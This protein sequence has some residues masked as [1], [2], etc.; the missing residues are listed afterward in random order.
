M[1][2]SGGVLSGLAGAVV[3]GQRGGQQLRDADEA[4][5]RAAEDRTQADADRQIQRAALLAGLADKG[6]VPMG[7]SGSGAGDASEP[8]A[9]PPVITP[10]GTTGYGRDPSRSK[11]A[12]QRATY[13][14]LGMRPEQADAAIAT[15]ALADEFVKSILPKQPSAKPWV[16]DGYDD[17]P[18]GKQTWLA[19]LRAKTDASREPTQR[20]IDP[21][22]PDGI[23]AGARR[24]GEVAKAEAPFKKDAN[25]GPMS[26]QRTL[27]LQ[28]HFNSDPIVKDASDIAQAFQKM[29]ASSRDPSAAGDM[30][31]LYGY[32]KLL[33]PGSVVRESEFANAARSGSLPQQI[34][35]FASKIISGQRLTPAQRTDFI[36]R[37]EQ[38]ARAQRAQ[39]AGTLKRYGDMATRYGVD[40][41]DIT[42]DPFEV[43]FD[44]A[45]QTAAGAAQPHQEFS[46][47]EVLA[48][49]K[50]GA[51]T[52][53]EIATWIRGH[54]KP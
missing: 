43:V 18:D 30:S 13:I 52:D 14:R 10:L 28:Q 53:A 2:I 40:P 49:H 23:A 5:R 20:N 47:A 24:A 31:L 1:G 42:Y 51:K 39:L 25:S 29:R 16:R 26:I 4:K 12:Q 34:Q 45:T 19:D 38:V 36:N 32:M 17:T 33:D 11:A 48:A 37:A 6:I 50:A 41:R 7:A 46:D 44:A 8:A 15:P 22:S 3:R 54:R 21:L 27:T 35:G 9:S